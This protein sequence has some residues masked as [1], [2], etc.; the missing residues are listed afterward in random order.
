MSSKAVQYK[1]MKRFQYKLM[2]SLAVSLLFVAFVPAMASAQNTQD[3]TFDSFSADYYLSRNEQNANELRVRET[4]VAEFPNVDQ[5]HG[6]LRAIPQTYKD[7][8]LQLHDIQVTDE[9]GRALAYTTYTQ[10]GNL[11]LKIGDANA[12]VHGQKTYKINYALRD[13][14]TF[15]QDH[16]EFYWDINGD[17]WGQP[18]GTV[19]ARVHIPIALEDSVASQERCYKGSY[20]SMAQDCTHSRTTN[21]EEIVATSSAT[22]VE[23]GQTLSVVLAFRPG[24]FVL[25]SAAQKEISRHKTAIIA[26]V[27]SLVATPFVSLI[28]LFRRW[29]QIGDDPKGRGVIIPEYAPPK[30]F[31]V[32]TSDFLMKQ[33]VRSV[34]SSATI[35]DS[36]IKG[37]VTIYEIPKKGILGSTDYRL[38]LNTDPS[39]LPVS[40]KE[41]LK[42]VFGPSLN[43][44]REA[45]ISDFK[46]SATRQLMY[47]NIKNLE[48]S[49]SASLYES[50]YFK[51]DPRKIRNTYLLI[52]AG[53]V[54]A[55]AGIGW[56]CFHVANIWALGGLGIGL[57]IS[58]IIAGIFSFIMPARTEQG[59]LV[60]D[61]LLGLKDYIKLA[62]ADRIK[63]LQS[64]AGVEK[65]PVADEFDPKTPEAKI[66]LFEKLLPYAMLFGLE[67][68][69]GKQFEG[70]YAS[71]PGWYRGSTNNFTTGYLIGS[72]SGFSSASAASFAPSSSSSGS[73]FSG[74][75]AGGGGGGGG[76]GGW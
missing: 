26:A 46:Q 50:G 8:S 32:L 1:T 64:P 3:F 33:S 58:G 22:T 18:F 30:G 42:L 48:K 39:P 6:I 20:G 56:V 31:D 52:A 4:L 7:H 45:K 66:K 47:E 51:T 57:V 24:T 9:Q 43:V 72:M 40:T 60:H 11:V 53:L 27:V 19:T 75:G 62:E 55:G 29:R 23:A 65:A 68:E 38:V 69:W 73:G 61:A 34:A 15:Y 28:F 49:L 63:F 37:Y 16:D 14:V 5:N 54:A 17:Q 76:G 74:G 12:Y 25:S 10:A 21:T 2:C 36:A 35:I 71:S 70:L 67:K 44:G 13:A 59:V 41:I